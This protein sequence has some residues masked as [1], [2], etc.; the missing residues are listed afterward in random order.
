MATPII[1]FPDYT[2]TVLHATPS[3]AT[4]LHL[5]RLAGHG[6]KTDE[7][8]AIGLP[9]GMFSVQVL[10][11]PTDGSAPA[12]VEDASQPDPRVVG[13]GRLAGDGTLFVQVVDISVLPA[14]QKRGLGKLVVQELVRWIKENVPKSCYVSLM[15]SGEAK[16]LYELYGFRETAAGGTVGMS[17]TG[18]LKE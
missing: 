2:Y 1:T 15:A 10:A 9:R 4:Y 7:A 8:C 18:K 14:H 13:M 11:H 17:Y 16:K 6:V 5:R 3:T 12:A